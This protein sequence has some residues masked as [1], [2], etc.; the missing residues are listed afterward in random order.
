MSM[1]EMS[2]EPESECAK[3]QQIKMHLCSCGPFW[4]G[5]RGAHRNLHSQSAE[6]I[7]NRHNYLCV[8]CARGNILF[9]IF[10][11]ISVLL[12]SLY[13]VAIYR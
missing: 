13:I 2:R 12:C 11:L 6:V 7:E 5:A 10:Q 8:C 9:T 4:R 3:M 1:V